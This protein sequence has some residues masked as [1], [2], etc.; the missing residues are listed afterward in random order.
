MTS[1]QATGT[2]FCVERKQ[3]QIL[4][5]NYRSHCSVDESAR[6]I[7][8]TARA[9]EPECSRARLRIVTA[10]LQVLTQPRPLGSR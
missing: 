4:F 3:G 5:Q 2:R 10:Y 9:G 1:A 6:E 7:Q 8:S